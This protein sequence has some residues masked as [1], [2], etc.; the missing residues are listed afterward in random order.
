MA[1]DAPEAAEASEAITD[2]AEEDK[3]GNERFRRRAAVC[4]GV[5]A[6][7]LA[8]SGVG[9]GNATKEMLNANIGASDTFAFYQAKTI[10]QTST[11]LAADG[12]Q[13]V[14]LTQPDLSD[15]ARAQIQQRLDSY[16]ATIGRYESEPSTGQGKEELLQTAQDYVDRRD[17]AARQDPNFDYAQ[18]LYQIAIVLGSVSIVATSRHLL[19]VALG[20]GVLATLLMLN[21]FLLIVPLPG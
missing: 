20:L 16:Q 19:M 17:R 18:A 5:L 4:I 15:D 6:M 7:L 2:A 3:A 1:F 14:L 9:G 12:L 11:Q 13:T 10:R 8:I 21:G